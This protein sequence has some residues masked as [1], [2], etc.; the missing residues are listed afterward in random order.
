VRITALVFDPAASGEFA[1]GVAGGGLA[2]S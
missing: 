2:A 1:L